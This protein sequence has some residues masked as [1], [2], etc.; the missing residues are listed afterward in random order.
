MWLGE[1]FGVVIAIQAI[2]LVREISLYLC[3]V[4][5]YKIEGLHVDALLRLGMKYGW[6]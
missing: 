1:G 3:C 4:S 2:H 5:F 6:F